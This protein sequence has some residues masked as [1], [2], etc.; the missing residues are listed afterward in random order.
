MGP[1][2]FK[3]GR[4]ATLPTKREP[5]P[6]GGLRTMHLHEAIR[7]QARRRPDACAIT[8]EGQDFSYERLDA[9]A[10]QI[11]LRLI[12]QG[13]RPGDVVGV[14]MHRSTEMVAAMLAIL[15]PAAP[16][17]RWTRTSPMAGSR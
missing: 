6:A 16:T 14:H 13:V 2:F 17:C 9:R 15:R 12:A 8:F 4:S 1:D 5:S 10:G 7:A 11:A 3:A